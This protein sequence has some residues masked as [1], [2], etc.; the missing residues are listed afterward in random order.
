MICA[1]CGRELKNIKGLASHLKFKHKGIS[2]K[3]YYT[4]YLM[5]GKINNICKM[6]GKIDSCQKYTKFISITRGF[7]KYC[8]S[9][10]ST[11]DPDIQKKKSKTCLE[12][13]DK[14]HAMQSEEVQ[15]KHKQTCLKNHGVENVSSLDWV[16][17]KK[18]E[19]CLKNFG[20]EHPILSE[21][22]QEKYK[23]TCFKNFGVEYPMQSEEVQEKSKEKKKIKFFKKILKYLEYL[24]LE[25]LDK[26]FINEGYLY[27]WKCLKCGHEFKQIWNY[28]QQGYLCPKCF[29][30][31]NGTSIGE[32]E[33]HN[34]IC[35]L[36]KKDKIEFNCQNVIKNPNTNHFLELDIYIP[37]KKIAIEYNGLYWHSELV[38]SR[39]DYHL[40]KT[41]L[42]E[43]Q[44][45]QL[46]HIFED[47]W[48]FKKEI[49]KSRLK[50]ILKINDSE[51]IHARKCIIKEIE[52]KIKNEFL[53]MYHIQ[54]KDA[55]KIKLGA[56]YNE[57]LV[58][59]MT[60]GKGNISKGSKSK[61]G[62]W[63]LN[64]FCSNSNYHIPGIAGKLLSYFKKNYEW[65]EIFSY[66]D[67]RWSTGNLY[68][69]LSFNLEYITK[70]NYWYI[71]NSLRIHRF[72][73]RKTKDEP[74]DI[75]EWVLRQKEGYTRIWDCG[76]L[77]FTIKN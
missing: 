13:Y 70:P 67:R 43:E 29:P 35:D 71:K 65:K 58:S 26:E 39:F 33:I 38:L 4:K 31:N 72:N 44:G 75:S 77:K 34:F 36:I 50:Q 3:E 23:Q 40:Q 62:V 16:K 37:E 57:E 30:R 25:F 28:I 45:I 41:N 66:A 69:N 6:Y 1:I 61:E 12:I 76:S 55:S 9:R 60:F 49:V 15:E 7:H 32:K 18:K 47:E 27:N 74:K 10:C 5:K 59:V 22:V 53:E 54:G 52:P 48:I 19:T 14:E 24:N 56:F 68:H 63:E 42:C 51:R 21:E 2:K 20:V 17:E 73:L 11:F 8:S 46:I 64:R